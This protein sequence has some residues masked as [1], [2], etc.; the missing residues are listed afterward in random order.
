MFDGKIIDT[1]A[2]I[3]PDKIAQKAVNAIGQFYDIPMN[4]DGTVIGL[5]EQGKKADIH[6]FLVHSLA[7]TVHQV[8]SINNFI[9]AAC[10][11]HPE[12][13]GYA[14]LHPDMSEEEIFTE[15]QRC[16]ELNLKGIKLHPDFQQFY[17]DDPQVLK[18]YR[19][20]EGQLPILFHAG[21]TRYEYSAP[22]RIANIAKLFPKQCIIAAHFGG[23]SRWDEYTCYT[24]LENVYFDTSSSL[25]Q[26]SPQKAKEIIDA[27][28]EDHFFFASDYP[29]WDHSIELQR[30]FNLPL[31][32]RQQEK[33][34]YLN[35]EN[36]LDIH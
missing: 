30:F 35:A 15:I 33:I 19:A 36:I 13:T 27:L 4:K 2:H 18:I 23:Y 14:T 22:Q 24:G 12:F 11:E 21:D 32:Y 16:K 34:L 5:I 7:T 8:Q 9:S 31:T 26:L 17:V 6:R 29:R 10:K 3:Y 25:F 28:G 20:T 1:H